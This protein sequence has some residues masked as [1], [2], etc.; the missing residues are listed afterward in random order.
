VISAWLV[1]LSA[2]FRAEIAN[3]VTVAKNAVMSTPLLCRLLRQNAS[4]RRNKRHKA[5]P[6]LSRG[7]MQLR[8]LIQL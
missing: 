4:K 1:A 6:G 8:I 5:G 2:P 3:Q 7:L